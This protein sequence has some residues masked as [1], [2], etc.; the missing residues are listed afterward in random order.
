M[1]SSS[2]QGSHYWI[3]SALLFCL[4][5]LPASAKGG[6]TEVQPTSVRDAALHVWESH[7]NSPYAWGGDDSITG[8]DCSGLV[9][10]GL[11]SVGLL[12]RDGDWTAADLLA[13]V[14]A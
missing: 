8:F 11:R 12:A 1:G 13:N 4:V 2:S 9:I 3:G 6:A 14:Y 7:L 10:E 5:A